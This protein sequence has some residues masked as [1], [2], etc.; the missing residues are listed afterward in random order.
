MPLPHWYGL[1][2]LV[3]PGINVYTI[4]TAYIFGEKGFW[5]NKERGR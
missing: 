5:Y 1:P 4:L 2:S 3:P